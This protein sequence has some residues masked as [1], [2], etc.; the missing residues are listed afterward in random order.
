MAADR[1]DF[2]VTEADR[3]AAEVVALLDERRGYVARGLAERVKQ[4]DE[5]LR[6]R[7]AKAP[8]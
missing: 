6:L 3:A 4:V 5:Q 2:P 7:G 1:P 8:R